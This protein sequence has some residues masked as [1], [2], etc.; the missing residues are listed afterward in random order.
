M[1]GTRVLASLTYKATA[2]VVGVSIPLIASAR[3]LAPD[4]R[5][6]ASW[7]LRPLIIPADKPALPVPES[8]ERRL[9]DVVCKIGV[10]GVLELLKNY[11]QPAAA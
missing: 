6:L 1:D 8:P 4:Q 10:T 9:A 11:D 3:K 2:E 7:G 5:S